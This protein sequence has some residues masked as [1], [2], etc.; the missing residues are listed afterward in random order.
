[1]THGRF[2]G[3]LG[4]VERTQL[5]VYL[6]FESAVWCCEWAEVIQRASDSTLDGYTC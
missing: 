2:K 5:I 1:M 3:P 6:C 4:D